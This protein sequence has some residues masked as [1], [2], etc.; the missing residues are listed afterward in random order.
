MVWGAF[1]LLC[2]SCN[3][4]CVCDFG[5]E[6]GERERDETKVKERRRDRQAEG[7]RQAGVEWMEDCQCL[8]RRCC[9]VV[10][11]AAER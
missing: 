10:C 11:C 1:I 7:E 3:Y 2:G 4:L 8:L 6:K 5:E 9:G